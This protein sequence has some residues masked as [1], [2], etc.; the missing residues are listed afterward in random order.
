MEEALF[1]KVHA[2]AVTGWTGFYSG[3]RAKMVQSV[4][5]AAILF[6]IRE[7]CLNPILVHVY[8][9]LCKQHVLIELLPYSLHTVRNPL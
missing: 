8:P 2:H 3:M 6:W 7:V 4:T 9:L 1:T 5:A